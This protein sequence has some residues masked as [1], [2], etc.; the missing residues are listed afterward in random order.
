MPSDYSF[1]NADSAYS[2]A[3][4]GGCTADG[5]V[6]KA[7][8]LNVFTFTTAFST[9]IDAGTLID[10]SVTG[11]ENPSTETVYSVSFEV[12]WHSNPYLI[13]KF[14]NLGSLSSTQSIYSGLDTNFANTL[15]LITSR[16]MHST[17]D[18]RISVPQRV[19]AN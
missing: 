9:N 7:S 17:Q 2:L 15:I 5:S 1:S 3:C 12:I 6:T 18:C 11:F 16:N 4:N 8:S 10:I 13:D 14:E 19:I